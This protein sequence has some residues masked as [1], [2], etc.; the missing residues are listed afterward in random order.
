M[1]LSIRIY[2]IEPDKED[3]C[4]ALRHEDTPFDLCSQTCMDY[5]GSLFQSVWIHGH[6]CLHSAA[7]EL[8]LYLA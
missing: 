3:Y 7:R 2:M 5:D 4:G 1:G 8:A 6:R